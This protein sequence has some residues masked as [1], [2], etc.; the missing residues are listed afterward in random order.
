MRF[1]M[2]LLFLACPLFADE[3]LYS[4][5][6]RPIWRELKDH[7]TLIVASPRGG[8]LVKIKFI[9][10]EDL[11]KSHLTLSIY[12]AKKLIKT[13][14]VKRGLNAEL[15]WSPDS[16][17]FF[18]NW[19]TDGGNGPYKTLIVR[20]KH[21]N[22]FVFDPIPILTPKFRG[23][24]GCEWPESPNWATV[25]W[26]NDSRFAYVAGQ[27]VQHSNCKNPGH[28]KVF[29]VETLDGS[30]IR[31]IRSGN[32]RRLIPELLGKLLASAH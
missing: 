19:S 16:S 32:A 10:D 21:Q 4:R 20:V 25:G 7:T 26:T 14:K 24:I 9:D 22:V 8:I 17:S 13:I 27:V 1:L 30:V 5:D 28:F 29:V 18:L 12:Q 23:G 15:G 2:L 3:S 11:T 6:S 31:T